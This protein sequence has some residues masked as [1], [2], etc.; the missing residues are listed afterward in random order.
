MT[1][2]EFWKLTKTNQRKTIIQKFQELLKTRGFSDT[3]DII[4]HAAETRLKQKDEVRRRIQRD[5]EEFGFI[6][7]D[8][9]W[10]AK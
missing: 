7:V 4:F 8:F 1:K 5:L 2:Q 6:P 9:S 10:R 3:M